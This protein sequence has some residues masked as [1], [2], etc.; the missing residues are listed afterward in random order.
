MLP[1]PTASDSKTGNPHFETPQVFDKT[2][3]PIASALWYTIDAGKTW[4]EL[5]LDP[6]VS[7]FVAAHAQIFTRAV[8]LSSAARQLRAY[9]A[10][11]DT[12]F[13]TDWYGPLQVQAG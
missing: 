12:V 9:V 13:N 3:S 7:P 10:A 11:Q 4:Q 2:T 5:P 8:S 1:E 6:S